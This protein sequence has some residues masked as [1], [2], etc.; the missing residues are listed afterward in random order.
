MI[1]HYK[2]FGCEVSIYAEVTLF[3]SIAIHSDPDLLCIGPEQN[4]TNWWYSF[5]GFRGTSP[6]PGCSFLI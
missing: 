1:I 3:R 2:N 6:I 4:Q 5:T